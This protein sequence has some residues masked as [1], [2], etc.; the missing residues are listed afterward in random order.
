MLY[1]PQVANI[2]QVMIFVSI[3]KPN[4]SLNLLDKYLIMSE[5]FNVK[6]IIIINKTDLVDKETLDYY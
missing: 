6:P 3:V 5:K 2:D 4:I 1:R